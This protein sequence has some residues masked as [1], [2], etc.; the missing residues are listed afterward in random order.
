MHY[1]KIESTL[2]EVEL[3]I[4]RNREIIPKFNCPKNMFEVNVALRLE[5]PSPFLFFMAL[6]KISFGDIVQPDCP[7]FDWIWKFHQ[8]GELHP[9]QSLRRLVA[10]KFCAWPHEN[11]K[12]QLRVNRTENNQSYK[13]HS[14]ILGRLKAGSWMIFSFARLASTFES[15]SL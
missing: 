9:V 1:K 5:K 14:W 4:S 7:H 6:S 13:A 11:S 8:D 10:L 12:D 15:C 3:N 2:S